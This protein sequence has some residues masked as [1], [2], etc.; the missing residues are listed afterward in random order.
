MLT[1]FGVLATLFVLGMLF[2]LLAPLID[3][4]LGSVIR[5]LRDD[6]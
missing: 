1:L 2:V 5:G 6:G 3:E 4:M